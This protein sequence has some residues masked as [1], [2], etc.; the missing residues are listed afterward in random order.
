MGNKVSQ[1]L[2]KKK[3]PKRVI[4][5][6]HPTL[7][8]AVSK[9]DYQSADECGIS[10]VVLEVVNQELV[11]YQW[12]AK[13]KIVAWPIRCIQKFQLAGDNLSEAKY[14]IVRTGPQ[15]ASGVG[16]FQFELEN[17]SRTEQLYKKLNDAWE[18]HLMEV[19]NNT[20]RLNELLSMNGMPGSDNYNNTGFASLPRQHRRIQNQN[21]FGTLPSRINM[22]HG[23]TNIHGSMTTTPLNQATIGSTPMIPTVIPNIPKNSN[24]PT[25]IIQSTR[26]KS[27]YGRLIQ[28]TTFSSSDNNLAD[29]YCNI[30]EE[31]PK[32]PPNSADP[33]STTNFPLQETSGES[34]HRFV[35]RLNL[36]AP[37]KNR[38]EV[39]RQRK[40]IKENKPATSE[41]MP[42]P[43]EWLFN[44]PESNR[45]GKR[46][47][48]GNL[49]SYNPQLTTQNLLKQN[50]NPHQNINQNQNFRHVLQPLDNHDYVNT[51]SSHTPSTALT[52]T[53]RAS[54]S[55][56]R[57]IKSSTAT[58]GGT[59]FNFDFVTNGSENSRTRNSGSNSAI[60]SRE[61]LNLCLQQRNVENMA[62]PECDYTTIDRNRTEALRQR[63]T[64]LTK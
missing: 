7:F 32:Q 24:L 22:K 19:K 36:Q 42:H 43:P 8:N 13:R 39:K 23:V 20:N 9:S 59:H 54:G 49:T 18:A 17:K 16:V 28:T 50:I 12:N 3:P 5:D 64:L 30:M 56:G 25:A 52:H 31:S 35:T 33:R 62:N 46:E 41:N 55:G 44:T 53:T 29:E 2:R 14:L 10:Y 61:Q 60:N 37:P 51:R 27:T 58:G 38:E 6:D 34:N 1:T 4:R 63:D 15:C 47:I 45:G 21:N 26:Q 48:K 11:V 40:S 57:H